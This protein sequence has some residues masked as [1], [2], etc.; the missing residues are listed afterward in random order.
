MVLA[1]SRLPATIASARLA[2]QMVI[3]APSAHRGAK[4]VARA[5]TAKTSTDTPACN[6]GL[7]ESAV[8]QKLASGVPAS[9]FTTGGG[10]CTHEW[11]IDTADRT[12]TPA[13]IAASRIQAGSGQRWSTSAP[14]P[15]RSLAVTP[16]SDATSLP[17]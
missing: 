16:P 6:H 12:A 14:S 13:T 5:T 2:T 8:P 15:V 3:A 17:S 11:W 10:G 9:G 1:A 4:R 7:V